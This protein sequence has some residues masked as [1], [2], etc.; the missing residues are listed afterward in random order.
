MTFVFIKIKEKAM[1]EEQL[2]ESVQN[3]QDSKSYISTLVEQTKQEK[4]NRA[5]LE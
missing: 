2:N 4:R 5:K 3:L 1:L